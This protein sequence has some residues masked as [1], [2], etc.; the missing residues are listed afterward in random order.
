VKNR[1]K[2]ASSGRG[3]KYWW[4]AAVALILAAAIWAILIVGHKSGVQVYFFKGDK[5][6]SVTRPLPEENE[7]LMVVSAEL[8]AGPNEQEKTDGLFSE[9][10]PKAKI[11]IAEI[12]DKTAYLTFNYEIMNC[13]GGS[14]RVQGLVAQIVYTFTEIPGVE[15]VRIMAGEKKEVALGGEGFVIDRALSRVDV[16]F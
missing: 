12:K 14:A 11:M 15:K 7:R 9:I 2:A 6:V 16:K 1:K 3:T 5:L 10:P 4:W 13:G 8:I